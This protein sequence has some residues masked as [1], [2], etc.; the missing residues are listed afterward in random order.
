MDKQ[1]G[2]PPVINSFSRVLIL[3]SMPGKISLE[4]RQY[5]A[6]ARNDFWPIIFSLLQMSLPE[7]YDQRLDLILGKG[8][9]LWDVLQSCRREGSSDN[10]IRQGKSNGFAKLF[11]QYPGLR[12]VFFNGKK[13]GE[14]FGRFNKPLPP[15]V[16]SF[17][18]PSSSPAHT[19]TR[20]EKMEAWKRILNFLD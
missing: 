11:T 17:Y 12:A 15:D 16:K 6:N 3:G 4:K 5:Y 20:R 2:F 13:A 18:L 10:A 1:V 9:A 14:L 19:I 8:I 7:S